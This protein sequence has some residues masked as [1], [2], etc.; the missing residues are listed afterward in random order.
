MPVTV[1]TEYGQATSVS[2]TSGTAYSPAHLRPGHLPLLPG[3]RHADG[4]ADRD[5]RRRPRRRVLR[6]EGDR[7][8]R[9]RGGGDRRAARRLRQRLELGGRRHH[10]RA[11]RSPW[12]RR[13]RLTGSSSTPSRS[14]P[15]RPSVR[16]YTVSVDE[17][18][19]GWT[20]VAAEV[21]QYR[22]HE[23]LLAFA[24]VIEASAVRDLGERGRLRRLLRR[25][26]PPVVVP[27]P[28]TAP[29]SCTR[30]RSMRAPT[31]SAR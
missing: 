26:D 19:V 6:R 13:R 22:S 11:S 25:R 30:S 27:R 21:G 2:V 8:E 29:P 12:P 20:T 31:A 24:P 7:L 5:L 10:A 18:G 14:G 4:R 15:P 17:P 23:L 3:G 9:Q 16:N 28:R 1:T